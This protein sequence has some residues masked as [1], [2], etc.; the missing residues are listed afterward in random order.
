MDLWSDL[1]NHYNY[2]LL[3]FEDHLHFTFMESFN[4]QQIDFLNDFQ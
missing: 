2:L 1:S 3:I 4:G